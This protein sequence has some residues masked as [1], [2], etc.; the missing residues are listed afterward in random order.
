MDSLIQD[1]R[2]AARQLVKGRTSTLIVIATLALGIGANTSIFTLIN[3][4]FLRPV[5]AAD[6][7][8]LAWITATEGR[9][10]RIQNV[11]YPTFADIRERAKTFGGILGY[12]HVWLSLG[13][14][15]PERVRGELVTGNYFDVLGVHAARGRTFSPDEDSAPGA[16]PVAVISDGFWR[17]TG[18][19]PE[20]VNSTIKINGHSFTV[21]GVAPPGFEGVE[22]SDDAPMSVWVPMAMIATAQ[23]GWDD[24]L[25]DRH[26]RGW[27]RVI[28]R[29]APQATLAGARAEL[30]VIAAQLPPEEGR[31]EPRS[32][33]TALEASGGLDPS[34]KSDLLPVLSLLMVVPAL[35]LV[36]ACANAANVLLARAVARRKELAVRRALGA[37]RGRLVRQLLTESVLLS[38]A[39]GG[40]GVLCSFGFTSLIARFGEVPPG[41]VQA[42]SID[43]RVL[44]ATTIVA[45]VAGVLFGLVPALGSARPSLVPALKNEGVTVGVGAH[46]H[47][48]RDALVVGQVAVSLVCLVTAGLFVRSL[49]KALRTDPG[50]EARNGVYLSFDL[51]RQGYAIARRES[52]ER[53]LL[54]KVGALP[55]VETA[56]LASNVPFG[57]RY[58]GGGVKVEGAAADEQ[59]LPMYTASVSPT[60]F[61]ALRL[62][63]ARGRAFTAHDIV[64]APLVV[65][66]NE[67]LAARLWPNEDPVGKRLR[68][69]GRNEPLREVVGVA[70]EGRYH[71][72]NESPL[73]FLYLPL[74]QRPSA[75]LV[76]AVRTSTDPVPL[77]ASVRR[78]AQAVDPDLPWFSETTFAAALHGAADKQQA[79]AAMLAVFGT[80]ALL[81]AALGMYGVTAHGVALRT[82]EIGIRMSLGARS[83]E[84][85]ALF[86]R[87]GLGRTAVGVVIGLGISAALSKVLAGFLYGLTPT[88]ALTFAA[89][90]TVICGVAAIASY[91]PARRAARVEPVIALRAE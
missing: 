16:H 53:D 36:V 25:T 14:S 86:V 38:L 84:V 2:F 73:G 83:A 63:L 12:S 75:A 13:G 35:V 30:S 8:R 33:L 71:N 74:G 32:E 34:N 26:T 76:L 47:R 29:L 50:Y 90:A 52:F 64:G 48:L 79:A 85:L 7:G 39:A 21:V 9:S 77:V 55:G 87:E 1:L 37:S 19:D 66:V 72:L 27:L 22:I 60:Y 17:R 11:S 58:E 61:D 51:A 24:F 41:I 68:I 44:A 18:A 4:T 15:R 65:I 62:P 67:H 28:G 91:I 88:D 80:L 54:A 69:D 10:G 45:T 70:H 56:A 31:P 6:P 81:L 23:P 20:V 57:G 46:R 5:P 78:A 89:G 49:S 3:A 42:L 43:A 40:F 82:R 59:G